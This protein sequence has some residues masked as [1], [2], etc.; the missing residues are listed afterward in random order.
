MMSLSVNNHGN[1]MGRWE[2]DAEG[3]FRQAALELFGEFG[4]EQTTVAAIADRAGLT[5]RTFFRYFADKREVLFNG[6]ERLQEAMLDALAAAPA[7]AA[8]LDAIGA[9]L[10]A[11]TDFFDDARR[12]F[13]RL[14]NA[15]IAANAEL[16][17]RELIKLARLSAA[18]A[19]G[20]RE[21]GVPEPDASLAAE[22]GIAVFRVA[23][24]QW[25]ADDERRGYA[26]IAEAS[27]ARLRSLFSGAASPAPRRRRP[28]A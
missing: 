23:F 9:A 2:P 22:A 4:Y 15:V 6:S 5:A 26:E 16:H 11:P 21:R 7:G 27:L 25:V 19:A 24:A 20:L 13:S 3:R 12:P 18:L 1:V 28:A 8:A 10:L 14:R 17:E